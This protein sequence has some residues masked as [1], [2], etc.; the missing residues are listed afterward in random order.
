MTNEKALYNP[1][2]KCMH[3]KFNKLGECYFEITS[4]RFSNKLKVN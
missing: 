2:K 3:D 4:K 1:I